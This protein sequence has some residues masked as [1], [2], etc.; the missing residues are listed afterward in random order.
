MAQ[1]GRFF[2]QKLK[3]CS[4]N[5]IFRAFFVT[6][7]LISLRIGDISEFCIDFDKRKCPYPRTLCMGMSKNQKWVAQSVSGLRT[8]I[9]GRDDQMTKK[10][11]DF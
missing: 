8:A 7:F 1:Y 6:K 9:I 4:K 3:K 11:K 10:I 2:T 5:G